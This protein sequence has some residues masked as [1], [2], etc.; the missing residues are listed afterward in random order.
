MREPSEEIARR[1]RSEVAFGEVSKAEAD[2]MATTLIQG[3]IGP[4]HKVV[5]LPNCHSPLEQALR[6]ARER[7]RRH[8]VLARAM[9]LGH[10]LRRSAVSQV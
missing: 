7:R 3:Y 5:S 1:V 10:L 8:L 4:D 9:R 2:G 6:Q